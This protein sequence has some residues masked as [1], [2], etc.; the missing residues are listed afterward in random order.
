M[1]D[2]DLASP[3]LFDVLLLVGD[4]DQ[5]PRSDPRAADSE[6]FG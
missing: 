3:V 6:K 1:G 2:L 5:P 4:A